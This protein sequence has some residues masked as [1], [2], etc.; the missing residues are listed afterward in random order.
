MKILYPETL[1]LI[2]FIFM[3][4]NKKNIFYVLS[5]VF[6]VLAIS[7]ISIVKQKSIKIPQNDIFIL[8]DTTYSMSCNDI[9]PN[10][11]DYAKKE[12]K[13]ILKNVNKNILL[14]TFTDNIKL[15]SKSNLDKLKPT[16]AKTDI[17]VA[18]NK[19]KYLSNTKKTIVVVS[20][21]GEKKVNGD[22]VFFGIAT[23]KGCVLKDFGVVS[24]LNIIG[25][26][27]FKYNETDKLI[28][29]L[30][31]INK[32]TEKKVESYKSLSFVFVILASVF[33]MVAL[34]KE[35]FFMVIVLFLLYPNSLKANDFL[36]CLYEYVGLNKLAINEYK[37]SKSDFAKMKMAFYYFKKQ[38]YKKALKILNQVN[39]YK[40]KKNLLKTVAFIKLKKYKNAYNTIKKISDI[41]D[42]RV[43]RLYNELKK[44]TYEESIISQKTNSTK[45]I[46]KKKVHLW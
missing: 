37:N 42:K 20:D 18:V 6:L 16:K 32:Y 2:P 5:A 7:N 38:N 41:P 23:K 46:S 45:N 17:K 3:F 14:F 30:N 15:I 33:F 8:L 34:F 19:A 44:Y 36:G 22:F 13:K 28:N 27:Y 31:S 35:R 9:K 24:R 12:I 10:R 21:G 29:Y 26:K 11:L 4:L 43:Q 40:L 1:F 25:N 39:G